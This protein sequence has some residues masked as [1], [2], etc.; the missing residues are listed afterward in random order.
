MADRDDLDDLRAADLLEVMEERAVVAVRRLDRG[1][2]RVST[3]TAIVTE[4]VRQDVAEHAVEVERVP[5]GR[6][7][8]AAEGPRT[9]GD[10]T[11]LPVY[12][13]RLIV[14][15]RL[16][17]VEEVHLRRRAIAREA[18][19]PVELR[20]QAVEVT[21]L[22]PDQSLN[23]SHDSGVTTMADSSYASASRTL[24]AMFDSDAE[25]QRA[26]SRLR[27]AGI[28]ESSIRVTAGASSSYSSTTTSSSGYQDQHKGFFE[29]LG[30]FFFPDEDRYAYAEGL[31]RG[32]TMVAVSSYDEAHHDIIVDILD[33]EGSVD[34]S[35]R[36]TE[37]KSSGNYTDYRSSS[38]YNEDEYARTHRSGTGSGIGSGIAGAVGGAMAAA[39][40]AFGR[41]GA[42]TGATVDNNLG[43]AGSRGTINDDGYSDRQMAADVSGRTAYTGATVDTDLDD[44]GTVKVVE[45]RLA[46]GKREAEAGAVRVRSYVREVPVEADVE[47]R[48]TRV[49]VERRPVDRAIHGNVDF[50]DRTIEAREHVEE[51]VV[52][53]EARVVEEIGLRAETE[54]HVERVSDT[55]RK[56]EVEI[57]DTRTGETTRVTGD[58]TTGSG[59]I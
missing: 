8:E 40:D 41:S 25:A 59:R 46:V 28:P 20:R 36:E 17:L 39:G 53:K 33:D 23:I 19:V 14:E 26:V 30:D 9:E 16:Y 55:V 21:R 6:F 37:W 18:H 43:G 58:D 34:L 27:D 22:E 51:A 1:G 7:V 50:Q 35:A 2:V 12:E 29:S 5:V 24:T 49:H 56:T 3:R 32:S 13:E 15:K 44:D 57:E 4:D 52:G 45:E 11:I 42:A 48:S 31:T 47:L 10:L 54:S 38:Y